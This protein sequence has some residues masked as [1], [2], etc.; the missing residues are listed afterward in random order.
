VSG[1]LKV[2]DEE[3]SEEKLRIFGS[4]QSLVGTVLHSAGGLLTV[5][6]LAQKVRLLH[7]HNFLIHE[8]DPKIEIVFD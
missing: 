6:V 4:I 2:L 5:A 3:S 8:I 1:R 7:M